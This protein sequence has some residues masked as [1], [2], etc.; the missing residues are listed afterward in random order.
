MSGIAERLRS[1][2]ACGLVTHVNMPSDE[3]K[4]AIL[5][6]KA[7]IHNEYLPDDVA[8]F[9]A[10]YVTSNIRE[11]EGALIRV[12]AFAALTKQAVTFEL[13]HAVIFKTAH[14]QVDEAPR[15]DFDRILKC[16]RK[17]YN[18]DLDDLRS[19]NRNKELVLAR[20]IAMFLMKKM[21]NKSLRDIGSFL[22]SRDH[23]TVKHG[24]C[25]IE[26]QTRRDESFM[27]HLKR[28]QKEVLDH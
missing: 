28:M 25:K 27:L 18:Y 6:K 5:R 7:I 9:L 3:A 13:A 22:G 21:T 23:T 15:A 4:I 8:R 17:H 1:R 12:F 20:Q 10:S 24:L 26:E 19:K 14:M 16:I 11:L 2:L